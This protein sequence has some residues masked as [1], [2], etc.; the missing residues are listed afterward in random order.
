[1]GRTMSKSSVRRFSCSIVILMASIFLCIQSGAAMASINSSEIAEAI[2]KY[3]SERDSLLNKSFTEPEVS[4]EGLLQYRKIADHFP[5]RDMALYYGDLTYAYLYSGD[6]VASKNVAKHA[7]SIFPENKKNTS[8]Y[9]DLISALAYIESSDGGHDAEK[10]LKQALEVANVLDEPTTSIDANLQLSTFY[11]KHGRFV[12]SHHYITKALELAEK[13]GDNKWIAQSEAA[14]SVVLDRMGKFDESVSHAIKAM[15]AFKESGRQR[16][17]VLMLSKIGRIYTKLG[18]DKL[19]QHYYEK[20]MEEGKKLADNDLVFPAVVGL[21]DLYVKTNKPGRARRILNAYRDPVI[22]SGNNPLIGIFN[23]ADARALTLLGKFDEAE[24][25][26]LNALTQSTKFDFKST[27]YKLDHLELHIEILERREDFEEAL[28][29]LHKFKDLRIDYEKSRGEHVLSELMVKYEADKAEERNQRLQQENEITQLE[30]QV[31]EKKRKNQINIMLSAGVVVILFVVFLIIQIFNRK[32]LH[33]MVNYDSLTRVYNRYAL[34]KNGKK[35]VKSRKEEPLSVVLMD[36]DNFKQI[37]DSLGH[38]AGDKV[39]AEMASV[40][41]DAVRDV[42]W[43]GRLGG[44][45]FIAILPNTSSIQG[46]KVAERIL[47]SMKSHDWTD[48][49][50]KKPVTASMGVATLSSNDSETFEELLS[51]ADKAMYF[52]KTPG[53]DGVQHIKAINN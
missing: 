20:Q 8:Y 18:E 34:M 15:T 6:L 42:D 50:L 43:F 10:Y 4:L 3:N 16:F 24:S 53:K 12:L 9:Y 28:N 51:S 47:S 31:S 49:G 7:L 32:R 25:I 45:E 2:E 40:G 1:M 48:C 13:S 11:S 41:T 38:D 23:L 14:L 44:E 26:L 29:V 35:L 5:V 33:K 30:L 46:V 17:A 27:Q 36:I 19:A 37:N 22:E 21:A 39:L 52:V